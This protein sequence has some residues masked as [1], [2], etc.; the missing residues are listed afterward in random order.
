[1]A[2]NPIINNAKIIF[3]FKVN[4]AKKNIAPE[5][6]QGSQGCHENP[7]VFMA[8]PTAFYRYNASYRQ[9][10]HEEL[11]PFFFALDMHFFKLGHDRV[12]NGLLLVFDFFPL[13]DP[14][15]K[16]RAG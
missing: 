1:M 4:L 8:R 12:C 11:F 7:E 15:A 13:N 5:K 3:R 9:R 6:T 2:A 10:L 14:L 16:F